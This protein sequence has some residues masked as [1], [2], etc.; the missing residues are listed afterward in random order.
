[1][2]ETDSISEKE[3]AQQLF[4]E[5]FSPKPKS[6]G[7]ALAAETPE[8]SPSP[9]EPTAPPPPR[10]PP[11][12][13]EDRPPEE[14]PLPPEEPESPAEE[15]EE[16][17]QVEGTAEGE[18]TPETAEEYVAWATKRLGENP[19]TWARSAYEKE[20]QIGRLTT[21]NRE[22]ELRLQRRAEEAEQNAVQWYEYSQGIESQAQQ[23]QMSSMPLSAQEEEWVEQS[24]SNPY[25][26]AMSAAMSGNMNLY[27]GVMGALAE[28][29]PGMAANVGTQ[30][31]MALMQAEA[32]AQMQA[33]TMQPTLPSVT[34]ALG[35]SVNRL[36]IDVASYGKPMLAKIEELGVTHP[37][38]DTILNG[39]DNAR[40]IAMLAVLD[41]VRAGTTVTRKVQD[42]ERAQA[43]KREAELRK[44][45]AGVVT[46]A[47]HTPP[48]A[49]QSPFMQAM[50]DEWKARGQWSTVEE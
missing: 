27:N 47:P 41:L 46:G 19:E 7:E 24:F 37:F 23:A 31:Q 28:Q 5:V 9:E 25:G 38:V 3:L 44:E 2:S 14:T 16:E 21:Q 11:A 8:A 1:M 10:E 43:I 33:Q 12:V 40:D 34:E 15:P 48:P 29:D 50:E 13:V 4:E 18:V 36:G 49:K 22:N 32:Q 30:V 39:D 26:Y 17:G 6:V 20:Q 45:A 42:D 35:A